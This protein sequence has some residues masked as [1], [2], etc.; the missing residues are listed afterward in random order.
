MILAHAGH[1]AEQGW[2][3]EIRTA[4]VNTVFAIPAGVKIVHSGLRSK[5]GTLWQALQTRFTADLVIADI[6]PLACLLG[7]R[8]R[9]RLIYFAQ[10]Y[11]E[12]YYGSYAQ[13][14]FI[15]LL[16]FLTLGLLRIKSIAVAEHLSA[17]LRKRFVANVTTV[18]N[19][20]DTDI[21]FPDL[22]AELLSSKGCRKAVLL[23]SRSDARKGFDLSCRIFN[24]AKECLG[25]DG[26]EVWTVGEPAGNQ[27]PDVVHRDFGYVTPA[28]LRKILSSADVFLYHTRHEGFP[29]M[30]LEAL[31]CGCPMAASTS[32]SVV[33]PGQE[34]LIAP[35]GD[36]KSAAEHVVRI[37]ADA[38][39]AARLQEEG[40]A[41]SKR[42]SLAASSVRFAE[43][44][45]N[46]VRTNGICIQKD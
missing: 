19:G 34:A 38:S 7:V 31:A 13:R 22:D 21:F 45:F 15:R 40:L 8:N 42:H 30:A 29:L 2:K 46:R 28:R 43:E 5:A 20:V 12:S 1:L 26:V 39:L 24:E 6:I 25:A 36:I 27:F 16:Y 44:L 23:L 37:L 35:I 14:L 41:F 17:L 4:Q 9:Q 10:D 11:D 33:Y 32:V 3:V 18:E